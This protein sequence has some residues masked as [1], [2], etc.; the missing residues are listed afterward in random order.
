MEACISGA[1]CAGQG[2]RRS[3]PGRGTRG[4][5]AAGSGLQGAGWV[6]QRVSKVQLW[7]LVGC[8]CKLGRW[9]AR[10]RPRGRHGTSAQKI[11]E[12]NKATAQCLKGY[13]IASDGAV[14]VLIAKC[15][16]GLGLR[17]GAARTADM[18][19][20]GR[21]DRTGQWAAACATV[22]H[23]RGRALVSKQGI[24]AQQL[25]AAQAGRGGRGRAQCVWVT[26]RRMP[27]LAE[28]PCR[29]PPPAQCCAHPMW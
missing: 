18:G 7:V 15:Q 16:M 19:G 10:R 21:G 2:A 6:G 8:A 20:G 23:Q 3:K 12:C 28:R 1:V 11:C 29:A 22:A 4:R 13:M 26:A 24:H 27:L 5:Q 17:R 9:A 14:Q 25:A